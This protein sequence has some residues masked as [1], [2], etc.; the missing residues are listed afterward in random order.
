VK[1]GEKAVSCGVS[2]AS[3]IEE[4]SIIKELHIRTVKELNIDPSVILSEHILTCRLS[5]IWSFISF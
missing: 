3:E 1:A 4:L 5:N 2:N